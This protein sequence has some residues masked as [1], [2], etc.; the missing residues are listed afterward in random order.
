MHLIG[1]STGALFKDQLAAGVD[2]AR[3]LGT[4]VIELSALRSRELPVLVDYALNNSLSA[5]AYISV[6]APTDYGAQEEAEVASLL[7]SLATG[8]GWPVVVHPDCI[9]DRS[10]WRPFGRKL[11][12]E[13]MDKRKAT[14]RTVE[15][16]RAI[17]ADLPDAMLCFDLAHARQV[18]SSMTEAYRILRAFGSRICELHVSEVSS[19]SK[20]ARISDSALA[21]FQEVATQLPTNVPVI[22]E[23]PVEPGEAEAEM[24]QAARMF[25]RRAVSARR[26]G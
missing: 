15:E 18:D 11:C 24:V 25:E 12:I 13:N 1:F 10:L 14:G 6:H 2:M 9:V 21:A 3:T 19:S 20:H 4:E 22:L 26:V 16:L 8:R 7:F 23:S 17:L 5:F